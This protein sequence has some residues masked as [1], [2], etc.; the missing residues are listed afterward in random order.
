MPRAPRKCPQE[1]CE[2]RITTGRYC[3][4][5]SDHW[6][7]QPSGWQKPPNWDRDRQTV[8]ERDRGIC[9]LCGNPGADTVDHV[10][11]QARRGP[12]RLDNYA[13]VHDRAFPHCHRAKTNR[14]RA[15]Q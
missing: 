12:N 8:L 7:L 1:G 13:A 2:Q 9:Y 6:T 4:E 15:G 3:A 10:I 11:S 14:E 5:H